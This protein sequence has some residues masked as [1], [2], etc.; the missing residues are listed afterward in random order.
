MTTV[1]HPELAP[2]PSR[3][4][5]EHVVLR[6]FVRGDGRALFEA[7]EESRAHLHPWMPWVDRHRTERDSEA[8]ARRAAGEWITR[9]E[10]AVAVFD[11][12]DGFLGGSGLHRFDWDDRHFEIGYWLRASATGKGYAT[13]AA[14]LLAALAFER[15]SA[16]RVEI[17]CNA[18]NE[19]S[20]LVPKRLGF[21]YEAHLHNA[22]RDHLG[23]LRDTLVF[24]LTPETF[25][26]CEWRERAVRA[27]KRADEDG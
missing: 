17:R 22:Q 9:E 3:L 8:Y 6:P 4:E 12:H 19:R 24:A 18:E 26:A 21:V 16:A 11:R 27:V 10:L 15:L 2:L 7:I 25:A 5:G 20:A 23:R 1:F 13:E 14:E